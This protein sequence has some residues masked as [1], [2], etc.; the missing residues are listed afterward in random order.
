MGYLKSIRLPQE[1]KIRYVD[2][3]IKTPSI[4]QVFAEVFDS[5]AG[6]SVPKTEARIPPWVPALATI[7]LLTLHATVEIQG[8][9]ET[10]LFGVPITIP[11]VPVFLLFALVV[12]LILLLRLLYLKKDIIKKLRR[13]TV[14]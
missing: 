10:S 6:F 7:I 8:S 4:E 11:A 12:S 3:I 9:F 5:A 1:E 13:G 2:E 14:D